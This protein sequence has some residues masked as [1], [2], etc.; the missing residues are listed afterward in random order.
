MYK[1]FLSARHGR[2]LY[3]L[4]TILPGKSLTYWMRKMRFIR[5]PTDGLLDSAIKEI[6]DV[7]LDAT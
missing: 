5:Q 1:C 2:P 6:K 4:F 3:K 7:A